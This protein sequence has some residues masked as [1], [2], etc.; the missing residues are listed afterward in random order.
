MRRIRKGDQGGA[1]DRIDFFFFEESMIELILLDIQ[2]TLLEHYQ[3]K[4]D[5]ES[6]WL[7]RS[8]PGVHASK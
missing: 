8:C 7:R 5:F 2:A 3:F 6:G 1:Y 4:D